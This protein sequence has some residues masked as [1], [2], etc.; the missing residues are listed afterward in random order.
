[1]SGA[2]WVVSVSE[3][4][5]VRP[6]RLVP[7][8]EVEWSRVPSPI[9]PVRFGGFPCALGNRFRDVGWARYLVP[10]MCRGSVV[11]GWSMMVCSHSNR[12]GSSVTLVWCYACRT[13]CTW[14]GLWS[15]LGRDYPRGSRGSF[16]Q[17]VVLPP[18]SFLLRPH[19]S[20]PPQSSSVWSECGWYC[21]NSEGEFRPAYPLGVL[22]GACVVCGCRLLVRLGPREGQMISPSLRGPGSVEVLEPNLRREPGLTLARTDSQ[23]V[24]GPPS[25]PH[26]HLPT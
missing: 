16:G 22:R 5:R 25:S 12:G 4:W 1:M 14:S 20:L 23:H 6:H 9:H 26:R 18:F 15:A 21:A 24:R 7:C 17:F 10:L 11:C 13:I 19:A 8:V 2:G 3:T